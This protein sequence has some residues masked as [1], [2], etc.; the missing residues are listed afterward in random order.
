MTLEGR[1]AR[2]LGRAGSF[3][4]GA[5]DGGA[6]AYNPAGLADIEGI[7]LLLDAGLVL[8]R[9]HYDRVDSGGNP[10]PGVDGNLNF[11][12]FPTLSITW[13]PKKVNWLTIAGGVWVPYLGLNSYQEKGPQR[14]SNISLD[15]SLVLVAELAAAFRLH[16]HVWLGAGFQIMYLRFQSTVALSGCTELNCA[17]EDPG[18]DAPTHLDVTGVTPSGIMG[19]TFAWPKIRGGLS[20][21]LPFW[22]HADGTVNSRLGSDPFFTNAS[23]VGNSTS[24]DLTIPLMLRL[25][26]EYRPRR[27]VRVEIGFDYEAWSM[28]K[29]ITIRPHGIYIDGVPGIGRY[30]LNTFKMVRNMQDTFSVHLGAEWEAIRGRLVVRAGYLFETSATPDSTMSVLTSDGLH[31]MVSL[32]LATRVK[33]VRIDFGY[34]HLFTSDRNVSNSVSLQLNPI[35]PSLARPV[36]N[37]RYKIDT[38]ILALGLDG[39]W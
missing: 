22:I 35:K 5:D 12:P 10:Q 17:P 27:T 29:D 36:G 24:A 20:L 7:S 11:L 4:A 21:Q 3:V 28:Q 13:K 38:D 6:I 18:F 37:G 8:Q 23:V 1:G 19:A 39:R 16:E 14:Y 30:Y 15:G 34:A 31:N 26:L 9:T 32:G 2:P 33:S 25:G